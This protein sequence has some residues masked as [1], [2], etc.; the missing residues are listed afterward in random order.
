MEPTGKL[1]WQQG[2][3]TAKASYSI[4]YI[5]ELN[6]E[7]HAELPGAGG[8]QPADDQRKLALRH[9]RLLVRSFVNALDRQSA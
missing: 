1:N 9:A 4:P 2:E 8:P 6:I 5:G 3:R 7:V